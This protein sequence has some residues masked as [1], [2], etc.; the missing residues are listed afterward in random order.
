[1]PTAYAA[2][3]GSLPARDASVHLLAR[4]PQATRRRSAPQ[5]A[6]PGIV[7]EKTCSFVPGPRLV[8]NPFPD[9]IFTNMRVALECEELPALEE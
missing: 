8:G 6:R 9:R 2:I 3:P 4:P 1:M 7:A 5:R